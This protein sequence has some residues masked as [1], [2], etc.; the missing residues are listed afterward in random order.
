MTMRAYVVAAHTLRTY[1]GCIKATVYSRPVRLG[2][3]TVYP[4]MGKNRKDALARWTKGNLHS[5][6]MNRNG[7]IAYGYPFEV[8]RV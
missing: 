3:S 6:R 2:R 5:V 4:V 7:L 8:E 1:D